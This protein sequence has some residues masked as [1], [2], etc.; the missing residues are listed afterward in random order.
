MDVITDPAGRWKA[1]LKNS[2]ISPRATQYA[3]WSLLGLSDKQMARDVGVSPDTVSKTIK[4]ALHKYDYKSR[5]QL[6][7][8]LIRHKVIEPIFLLIL[9]FTLAFIGPVDIRIGIKG[10][11]SPIRDPMRRLRRVSTARRTEQTPITLHIS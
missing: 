11:E 9:A 6:V 10:S 4:S 5:T 3:L 8:E 1:H 2:Y 7:A